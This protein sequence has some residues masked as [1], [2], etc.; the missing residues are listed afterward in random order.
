MLHIVGKKIYLNIFLVFCM[1]FLVVNK[2]YAKSE[3]IIY[4]IRDAG[5]TPCKNIKNIFNEP[6]SSKQTSILQWT[7]GFVA[8][9]SYFNQVIDVFPIINTS[10]LIEM[11]ILVCDELSN[12]DELLYQSV[13]TISLNRLQK[14]WV[15]KSPIIT[16]LTNSGDEVKIYTEVIDELQ[17]DII[18]LGAKIKMD[19]KF[20]NETG[21]IIAKFHNN[22][23]INP[24]P[25]PS[26]IT[27]YFLTKPV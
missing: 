4:H 27:L 19:G 11:S 23:G 2:V 20:G 25:L 13:I 22:I 5:A 9:A 10:S 6:V 26:G 12:N 18:K 15:K 1:F 16:T 14:Y 8:S 17:R 3:A 21:S 7:G 24:S